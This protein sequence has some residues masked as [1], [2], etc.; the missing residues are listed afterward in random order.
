MF[1]SLEFALFAFATFLIGASKGGLPAV[2][3]LAV[4]IL[5]L[6]MPAPLAAG[7]LLPL[8][9]VS[10]C[11]GLVLFRRSFSKKNL[12]LF[13]PAAS[14]GVV[15]GFF[16]VG[17]MTA[18]HGKLLVGL[19]GV[20]YLILEQI[21][22]TTAARHPTWRYGNFWGAITG[23]TSYISHAGGPPFQAYI[24]PQNLKKMIFAGTATITFAVINFIKLPFYIAAGQ[25]HLGQGL[26]WLAGIP[27]ALAGAWLGYR[28]IRIIN[29]VIFFRFVKVILGIISIKLIYDGIMTF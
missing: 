26:D 19:I 9:L 4:P 16:A 3:M 17:V 11:Y 2:S 15:I 13:L 18:A 22:I 25:V 8:Y 20:A 7:I 23:F 24:L 12:L 5:S 14:V 6:V 29:E 28:L 10:D 21:G 1:V 27:F